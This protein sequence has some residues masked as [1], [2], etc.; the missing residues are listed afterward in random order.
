MQL[1]SWHIYLRFLNN[2][3]Y[4]WEYILIHM[5]NITID[6]LENMK[7]EIKSLDTPKRIKLQVNTS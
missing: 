2:H 3:L 7:S 4:L 6:S 1:L 5:T